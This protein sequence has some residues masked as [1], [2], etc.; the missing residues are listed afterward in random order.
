MENK[1]KKPVM[2]TNTANQ[3]KRSPNYNHSNIL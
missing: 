3:A 1:G 2:Q